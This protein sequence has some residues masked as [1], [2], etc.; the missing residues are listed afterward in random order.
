[1]REP[2]KRLRSQS[3]SY[4]Q[5][6]WAAKE[7]VTFVALYVWSLVVVTVGGDVILVRHH[8]LGNLW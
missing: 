5:A 7:H 2:S 8:S 4:A 3:T 6:R 1:V